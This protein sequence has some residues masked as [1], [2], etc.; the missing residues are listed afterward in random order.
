[1]QLRA[2]H[3]LLLLRRL[4][5]PLLL[6]PL[7][8][9]SS[10]A[11]SAG[12][13]DV[14]S[15][16][17][18]QYVIVLGAGATDGERYAADRL[19]SLLSQ[20]P[21][22][23]AL[24]IVGST[25]P[26]SPQLAVGSAAALALLPALRTNKT[27]DTLGP[28]GFAL[29][30][31][32]SSWSVAVTG[33]V[34]A[35]RGALY[36]VHR[37]L[38]ELGFD[39]LSW[40]ATVVPSHRL[41]WPGPLRV[42]DVP[43]LEWR[44]NNNANLELNAHRNFS[45]A[46]GNNNDGNTSAYTTQ[47]THKPG[48]GVRWADPPGFVHT[49][50]A[51][52][53][54]TEHFVTHPEWFA[55]GGESKHSAG[56]DAGNQLCWGNRSLL[57]FIAGRAKQ[58]LQRDPDATVISVSQM[59]GSGPCNRSA[60]M[61]IFREEGS[62]M[63]PLLRGVNFVAD[64][65]AAAFPHRN[66]TV[67]T[68]A[69]RYTQAPPKITRP[70]PNVVIRV[71]N[72]EAGFGRPIA[73]H[74]NVYNTNFST[75]LAAWSTVSDRIWV[76]TYITDF[77]N[78]L[79]PWPDYFTLG[80]NIRF[81]RA[82]G[83]TGVYQEGQYK[84]YGGDMQEMKSWMGQKLLWNSSRSTE[85]LMTHF[86]KAWL[87]GNGA[88]T[89]PTCSPATAVRGVVDL[90]HDA[91][92]ASPTHACVSKGDCEVL[93]EDTGMRPGEAQY[94]TPATVIRALSI[95][96]AELRQL[97]TRQTQTRHRGGVADGDYHQ[98]PPPPLLDEGTVR[99]RL[100]RVLMSSLYVALLR[101]EEMQ[102]YA[103]AHSI[104]W[105]IEEE[106][107]TAAYARFRA[108]YLRNAMDC[109]VGVGQC[110]LP[111]AQRRLTKPTRDCGLN[112]GCSRP[113]GGLTWLNDTIHGRAPPSDPCPAS[114]CGDLPPGRRSFPDLGMNPD[115]HPCGW[116]GRPSSQFG[117]RIFT[118]GSS[119]RG[120]FVCCNVSS[121]LRNP[122]AP[123]GEGWCTVGVDG[124]VGCWWPLAAHPPLQPKPGCP[125]VDP[126]SVC[127][128]DRPFQYGSVSSAYFCCNV[129]SPHT[130]PG[131][132]CLQPGAKH[133]DGAPPCYGAPPPPPPPAAWRRRRLKD[134]DAT[135]AAT[136][137][138][139]QP[140]V[141]PKRAIF[142]RGDLLAFNSTAAADVLR[143]GFTHAVVKSLNE[144]QWLCQFHGGALRPLLD[145]SPHN[146][147]LVNLRSLSPFTQAA[148]LQA[149][150]ASLQ[151]M[152]RAAPGCM[153]GVVDDIE[154][155]P[156][157]ATMYL[158]AGGV[159][160]YHSHSFDDV[161]Q[162]IGGGGNGSSPHGSRR[163]LESIW[164]TFVDW[165]STGAHQAHNLTMA[166]IEYNFPKPLPLNLSAA[167]AAAA[168]LTG[169]RRAE[170][171]TA[172]PL[173]LAENGPMLAAQLF[174]VPAAQGAPVRI[175]RADIVISRPPAASMDEEDEEDDGDD[176]DDGVTRLQGDPKWAKTYGEVSYYVTEVSAAGVPALDR[177]V[178]CKAGCALAPAESAAVPQSLPLYL[179]PSEAEL[180]P[181][182]QYAFVFQWRPG[183][184]Q[185]T[186]TAASASAGGD[187]ASAAYF[188]ACSRGGG[189]THEP[190]LLV[191][192]HAGASAVWKPAAG[193]AGQHLQL[194]LYTPNPPSP[195]TA[196]QM[197]ADWVRFRT[198]IMAGY[199][200]TYASL[201]AAQQSSPPREVYIYSG[202]LGKRPLLSSL[203][204]S[205]PH[206]YS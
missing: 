198:S 203:P 16:S 58:F 32:A 104:A 71:C 26:S 132:C 202:Y 186:A 90:F 15:P 168:A 139:G 183:K 44:H 12:G 81:Y 131:A 177:L 1:M 21:G 85:E 2:A 68:L 3:L 167:S 192:D 75:T 20:L 123:A 31:C 46:L 152:L 166:N 54:P 93:H 88:A 156:F 114:E 113:S 140:P 171:A 67:D 197:H 27:L 69:Y 159:D 30:T 169:G 53:P 39:F 172:P 86:L 4:L 105:P 82:H 129:S 72:I 149:A 97:R 135:V 150:N 148:E 5:L 45:I 96:Q 122:S 18:S 119:K 48:G 205:R 77:D 110:D 185:R 178:L 10:Y 25:A 99:D 155:L 11:S 13:S 170:V 174:T 144:T 98:P 206:S 33:G 37:Y 138:T 157:P 181:G 161:A 56:T 141:V 102:Q 70:R 52:V 116:N 117:D 100:E 55:G 146:K 40:N 19:Q 107:V 127:P 194:Q 51:L 108:I 193:H 173:A 84:A 143:R 111:L 162:M 17:P 14:G 196:N 136:T 106:D 201:V 200:Q 24:P 36:G 76:W 191:A 22:A 73:N 121:P 184:E 199:V 189:Q 101:W 112:E 94:L 158:Q 49:S 109:E 142:W 154:Q 204:A 78:W 8:L 41:L 124:V 79:M 115:A 179:D 175:T 62:W 7:L 190:T 163:V 47:D 29:L 195:F 187:N 66:I 23:S 64:E 59:D 65:V 83:V 120:P 63:G 35:P 91:F 89:A 6:L 87:C 182:A 38:E 128:L 28:E 95:L 92:L 42:I 9:L 153:A 134:D 118:A 74:T 103:I 61:A 160:T 176:D 130:C 164:P 43:E 180:E 57:A 145:V 188:L 133:C 125:N 151:R 60:D 50:F 34:G 126:T 80:P 165:P 137:W 147:A